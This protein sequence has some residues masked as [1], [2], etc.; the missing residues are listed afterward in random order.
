MVI[1]KWFFRITAVVMLLCLVPDTQLF[2][3]SQVTP[4]VP[5]LPIPTDR[6][7]EWQEAELAMFLHF[8]VNTFTNREWG[9][10]EENP[11]VFNPSHLN[12]RQ[13]TSVAKET[14]FKTVILT[15][16]HHD[17]FCL[18][19]SKYT[20]HSVE[21]SPWKDG[22]GDVVGE[23]AAAAKADGLKLGLYLSPWDRHE[24]VYGDQVEYNQYYF[25]QL[26]ELVTGYG[27]LAEVWFD[28]AK[29]A[30]AKDMDY[31]FDAYWSLVRQQQPGAVMFSD[32]GP[33]VRW[34][35]NEDGIAGETCWSMME[36]SQVTIGKADRDLLNHGDP[37]GSDWVPGESDVSIR[38][39]WFWHPEEEPKSVAELM[40]IYYKSVGRNTVLLLN[41]PPT[42]QGLLDPADVE[43]L[44]EFQ[45]A[46]NRVFNLD[47]TDDASADADNVR[48]G[49]AAYEA[50]Q[51]L[52]KDL[53]TYWATDNR[54]T[55]GT[56]T[57]T[58]D[59]PATFNVIRMQEPI[60]MGQ[61]VKKYRV[62]A[63]NNNGWETISEGTTIG[64][65]KLD[66]VQPV[67]AT[68][69]RLI[70]E[71]SRGCPLLAEFGLHFDPRDSAQ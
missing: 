17:G 71:D 49:D 38:P 43:R 47:Y 19:P 2:A 24:P 67:T 26:Q 50:S 25:G 31:N 9:T 34:I 63:Y 66:L 55:S 4:P 45:E 40:D 30:D 22:A 53:S 7:L 58:L 59:E 61:R 5:V 28:G 21:R 57:I 16:K 39:G 60:T 68:R 18:W 6:Q 46:R 13:W 11:A 48:G 42:D 36:R 69:I 20:D 23:L 8:G 1:R 15:A 35:G 64:Y 56:L 41:V 29:G 14:G 32:A 54:R 65:K 51:V 3:Q 70:I 44:Y 33:D 10:G 12:T 62:Q 27:D 52:D 37:N